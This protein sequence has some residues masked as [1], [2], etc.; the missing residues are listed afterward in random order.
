MYAKTNLIFIQQYI[1]KIENN[2]TILFFYFT[3]KSR[4]YLYS[5]MH[6]CANANNTYNTI[7]E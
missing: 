2:Y 3:K 4:I 6:M 1:N 7:I 5:L